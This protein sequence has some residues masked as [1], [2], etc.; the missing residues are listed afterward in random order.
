MLDGIDPELLS[1]ARAI[2][3]AVPGVDQARALGRW[4]G[5]SLTFDIDAY[6]DPHM[7]VADADRIA[8]SVESNI[9]DQI[10]QAHHVRV[11]IEPAR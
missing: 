5:R 8:T 9:K 6:L 4:S 2:A 1:E 10:D 7:T 3:E 11:R